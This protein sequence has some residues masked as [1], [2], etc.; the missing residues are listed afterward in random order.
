MMS[1][2][3]LLLL[4]SRS[5]LSPWCWRLAIEKF[6]IGVYVHVHVYVC[7]MVVS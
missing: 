3:W 7:V 4:L 2:A 5:V 1:K 6:S